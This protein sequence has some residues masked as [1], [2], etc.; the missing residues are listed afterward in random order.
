MRRFQ[1]SPMATKQK[2]YEMVGR[3][4]L[5]S[6]GPG[7]Q[8]ARFIKFFAAMVVAAMGL[9]ALHGVISPSDRIYGLMID[10][11]S[12]GSRIHTFTFRKHPQT[13]QLRVLH[14]DFYPI[15]PGL[16]HYKHSPEEAAKSLRPLLDRAKV[17]VPYSLHS[18]TPVV[19]RATAGLRMVG[20]DVANSI[21]TEVRKTLRASGFRFEDDSWASILTGNEEAVYSWM[22]VNYLLGR[23]PKN[24]VGTLELGGGS[25][26]VAYV[27]RD[28]SIKAATG[29]CS[30][31][32]EKLTFSGQEVDLYTVSHLDF[33]LQKARALL[34]RK[35]SESHKVENNPC[36]NRG[37]PVK[38]PIPFDESGTEISFTGIGDYQACLDLVSETLIHPAMG[39]CTCDLCTYR[40]AAQPHPI[41]EFVAFAFYLERTV[42]IGIPT[43]MHLSDIDAKGEEI[44]KLTVDEVKEKYPNVP[45]G[46]AVDL[47]L[48]ISYISLHLQQGHG[49]LP[50]S[51][52]SFSVVDKIN[53]FELGWCLGAMQQIMAKLKV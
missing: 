34:F 35:F 11:G 33:G 32:S 12:T 45:N 26:Q 44:C 25:S 23:G 5:H 27:P 8:K 17:R 36:F 15:K 40:G 9:Y 29:N 2:A 43:P 39:S 20:E 48:D 10:A 38:V 49:I 28:D 31:N 41:P 1:P 21:L 3:P 53:N 22:T 37:M 4:S 6:N 7:A 14:E 19:L 50:Q 13:S 47:C 24:T 52:T 51:T 42:S 18:H 16:S 46:Q 30:L